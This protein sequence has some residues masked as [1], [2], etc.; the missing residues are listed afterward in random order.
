MYYKQ[1]FLAI[2]FLKKK[3]ITTFILYKISFCWETYLEISCLFQGV[4]QSCMNSSENGDVFL[5]PSTRDPKCMKQPKRYL[6]H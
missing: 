1:S 5:E 2:F 6:E 4:R 3:I